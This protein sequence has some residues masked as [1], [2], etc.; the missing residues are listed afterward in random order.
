MSIE[1]CTCEESNGIENVKLCRYCVSV[2][3][4]RIAKT[5]KEETLKEGTKKDDGKLR[6]DLVPYDAIEGLVKVLTFGAVK[7]EDRNWEKGITYSRVFAACQRH[8]TAWYRGENND[9]ETGLSHLDH[10]LCC[11]AFLS[12]FEK[13]EM[14]EFDNRP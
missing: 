1:Q 10:A 8:L 11:V 9:L 2:V 13:R 3:D 6:W 14:T 12:A 7:Y 4:N 5:K